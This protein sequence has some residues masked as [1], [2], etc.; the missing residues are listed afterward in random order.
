MSDY[1]IYINHTGTTHYDVVTSVQKVEGQMTHKDVK[2][3]KI[4][5]NDV[6]EQ[7]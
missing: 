7:E 2:M 4:R 1:S 3:S 6:R 5:N